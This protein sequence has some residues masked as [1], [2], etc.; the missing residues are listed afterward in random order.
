MKKHRVYRH[1]N[2]IDVDIFVEK[3]DYVGKDY[4][5][6]HVTYVNQRNGSVYN[7]DPDKIKIYRKDL[8]NWREIS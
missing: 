8:S 7:L 3:L 2:C 4:I 5:K 6:L 1:R